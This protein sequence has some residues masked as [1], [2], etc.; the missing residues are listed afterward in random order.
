MYDYIDHSIFF[1]GW[2]M[3]YVLFKKKSVRLSILR[4][5]LADDD[6]KTGHPLAGKLW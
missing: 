3:Q 2:Y 6:L 4:D 1:I 5:F